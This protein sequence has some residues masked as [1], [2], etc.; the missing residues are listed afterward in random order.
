MSSKSQGIT[1]GDGRLSGGCMTV[2]ESSRRLTGLG[3]DEEAVRRCV[4]ENP[5]RYLR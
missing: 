1:G 2:I 5:E 3:I 4:T